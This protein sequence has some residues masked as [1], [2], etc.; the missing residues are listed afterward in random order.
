MALVLDGTAGITNPGAETVTG[1]VTAASFIGSGSSLTGIASTPAGAIIQ[2]AGS[3]APSGYLVC[4]TSATTVSRTTYA[5]LFAAIGTTWGAGDGSTTFNIPAFTAD[6]APIQANSNVG[7]TSTGS[8]IA[9]THTIATG[10]ISGGTGFGFTNNST[11]TY[12][13]SST[14]G[15]N[16]LAAGARVL[17]C[18]KY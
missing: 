10:G 12:T 13:T 9:H 8:V 6:F 17:F 1:N 15:T 2:Y 11:S 14:G 7:T 16:N 18:I 5:T 4:P 3:S